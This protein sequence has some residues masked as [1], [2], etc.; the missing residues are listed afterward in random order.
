MAVPNIAAIVLQYGQWHKT[1]QCLKSLLASSLPPKWIIVVDNASAD[2]SADNVENW[3]KTLHGIQFRSVRGMDPAPDPARL[4]LIKL[5]ANGGYAA[6]NN[7]G[8]ALARSWN[9]DAFLIINNDARVTPEALGAMWNRLSSS[10]KPGLCGPLLVY[11]RARQP[12][13]CC[14][15]GQTNYITG[16]SSFSG[17]GIPLEHAGKLNAEQIEAGLNFIC[18]ACFLVSR[19]FLETVG[20]MDEGY[21]LYCEEQDWALRARGRF[22]LSYAPDALVYHDE[23]AST[24]WNR[25]AFQWRSSLRMFRSRLRLAWRH[26]PWYLPTVVA[27][28]VFAA[29]RLGIKKIASGRGTRAGA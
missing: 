2:N 12:I 16:L 23:G 18:G 24:G 7:A 4:T 25:Y 29:L 22:D 6:G 20:F 8:L 15:G 26:H 3:C 9:A 13:Q 27:G 11:S 28:C 19:S 17:A 14:A 5:A 21:F 1:V 10:R